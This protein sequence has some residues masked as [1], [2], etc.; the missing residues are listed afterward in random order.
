MTEAMDFLRECVGDDKL[1]LG[2]G[3]PL[4]PAF[5]RVDYCRISCDVGKTFREPWWSRLICAEMVSTM[6]AMLSTVFRRH[7]DG[8]AFRND[9][10]VAYFRRNN[11]WR[12][13]GNWRGWIDFTAAQKRTLAWVNRL[14]GR[15]V[16]FVSDDAGGYSEKQLRDLLRYFE[17]PLSIIISEI[18]YVNAT[19][20]FIDYVE[21]GKH[22]RVALN[23]KTGEQKQSLF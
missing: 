1:I 11:L 5:G 16:L 4:G 22:M 23:P 10:D 18:E 19:K 21:G 13:L 14:F 17:E 8:R 2:C 12:F 6:N 9:P 20:I 3:V 7:L 15:G